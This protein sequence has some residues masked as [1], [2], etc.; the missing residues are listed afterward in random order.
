MD[1]AARGNGSADEHEDFTNSA[2]AKKQYHRHSVEQIQQLEAFFKQCPHPDEN[3]RTQISRDLGLE[4]R[5]IKFW[6]QNKRTQTKAQN[7]RADNNTLRTENEIFHCENLAMREALTNVVCQKCEG[8]S[9]GEEARQRNLLILRAENAWLKKEHERLSNILSTFSRRSGTLESFQSPTFRPNLAENM[10]LGISFHMFPGIQEMEKSVM[11]ET[12]INAMNELLGLFRVNEPLWIRSST[13]GRYVL[14]RDSYNKLYPKISH[15]NSSSSWIESSKDS[16]IVPITAM[17]LIDIFQD[18]KKSLDFFPTI[19]SKARTIEVL[20]TGKRGGSLYLMHEKLHVLSPLIAP[21]ESMFLRYIQQLDSTTWVIA[22]ISYD[23]FKEQEDASSSRSWK[24]PS[25][26]IIQDMPNGKANVTWVEHVQ[27]DDKSLTHHLYKDIVCNSQAYGAN[28]WIVT[29]Q[30]MCERFAFSMGSRIAPGHELEGVIDAPEG[31]RNLTKLSHK[32]IKNFYEILSMPEKVDFPQLSELNTNGFRVS[33]RKSVA[34]SQSNEMIVC[35]TTS[36]R[37]PNSFE[38]LF[39][40]FKDEK[41]RVQWDVLS[42]GN[43]IHELAHIS[44][45]THPGNSI[46]LVQ[47]LAPKENDMLILQESSIDSLGAFLIYASV[48]LPAITSI[49]SG[50]DNTNTHIL[51]SGFI[52]SSDGGIGE[53]SS[54]STSGSNGSLLT[55]AFQLMVR[56]NTFSDQPNMDSV[57]TIHALI[58]S[59]I[60][61]IRMAIGPK[62]E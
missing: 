60:Q 6:F 40:L 48:E 25:G 9:F 52:I 55:L 41:S 34:S 17:H 50:Q 16:G 27:V 12:T 53:S 47:P 49:I 31:K 58:N 21:R 43:P 57:T 29:L 19:V 54:S 3:Q 45:G 61:K 5:Q 44:T 28:R 30:R 62:F 38:D 32:M 56:S 23:C 59:T 18:P 33:I 39:N 37:L 26:C 35:V 11:V 14:D 8:S 24:F 2:K 10:P 20:D 42:N 22:N 46:S 13:N 7:E 4:P 15:L 51:P 1:F 36:L